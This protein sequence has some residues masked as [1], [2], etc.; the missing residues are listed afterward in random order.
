VAVTL[1]DVL[2]LDVLRQARAEVAVGTEELD[3]PVRWVHIGEAPDIARFLKGGELLLTGG[4]GIGEEPG[5]QRRYVRELAR[6]GAVGLVVELGRV[7][8]ELPA[9]LVEEGRRQRFPIVALHRRIRYVDVTERV[10]AAIISRQY[11]LLRKAETASRDFTALVLRGASLKSILERLAEI[12]AN[13]VVLEDASH[14]IVDFA[15]HGAS[16][17]TLLDAW[18]TH[19][20]VEH[21]ARDEQGVR[22]VE[23]PKPR[24]AWIPVSLHDELWGYVHLL[25]FDSPLDDADRLALDRGAAALGLAL[26]SDREAVSLVNDARDALVIDILEGNY[27]SIEDVFRR[28]RAL[29][30]DI[31]GKELGV[32]AV[33]SRHAAAPDPEW[34]PGHRERIRVRNAFIEA[35]RTAI[36]GAGCSGLSGLHR[37]R[38]LALVGLPKGRDFHTAMNDIARRFLLSLTKRLSSAEAAVGAS[39]RANIMAL[40]TAFE[41]AIEAARYGLAVSN[42]SDVFHFDQL[43]IHRLLIL[44]ADSPELPRFVESELGPLFHHDA[45]RSNRLL[46]TLRAYLEAGAHKAEAARRLHVERRSLYNRLERIRRLLGRDLDDPDVFARLLLALRARDL[47]QRGSGRVGS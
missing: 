44:L 3:R 45:H 16:I 25:E 35:M 2:K 8:R 9:A 15:S 14:R 37:D 5:G 13:P 31:E 34:E 36:I 42:G 40:R 29:D 22:M 11:D 46:P 43:G 12:A 32:L 10:H 20:R 27:R 4:M 18:D 39:S 26:L 23:R 41:E 6:V 47:L 30:A 1:R 7:F 28:A 19:A 33:I 38:L 17:A 24:C 21:E